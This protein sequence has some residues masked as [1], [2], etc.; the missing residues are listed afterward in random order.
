MLMLDKRLAPVREKDAVIPTYSADTL[1][2]S[3]AIVETVYSTHASTHMSMGDT[4]T[5]VEKL[6]HWTRHNKGCVIGAIV[7]RYGYGK[8]STAVHLWYECEKNNVI[9]V[10]PFAWFGL[11]DIIGATYTWVNYR[12]EQLAPDYCQSLRFIYDRYCAQSLETIAEEEGTTIEVLKGLL[13]KGK[14][15]LETRPPDVVKFLAEVNELVTTVGREGPVVFT[16]ELQVTLSEYPTRDQFMEDLFGVLNELHHHQG[17]YGIVISMPTATETLIADVRRDI[18]D[19]MQGFNFYIRPE[20]MYGRS[21]ASDLWRKYAQVFG[22][23]DTM[24]NILPP[25]TLKSIGQ[26]ASRQD[27]G[28]GPRTVVDAFRRAIAYY[29]ESNTTYQPTDLIDD[30]LHGEVAFDQNGKL[31]QVVREALGVAPVTGNTDNE[32]AIKLL[33]AFPEGCSEEIQHYYDVADIISVLPPAYRREYLY[34]FAEGPSLR[35][36]AATEV[37]PD[38]VFLRLAKEFIGRYKEDTYHGQLALTAFQELIL[39]GQIFTERRGTSLTGWKWEGQH[40]LSGTF[41]ESYPDRQLYL[42]AALTQEE[43]DTDQNVAEF[44]IWIQL[45]L[46]SGNQDPG[47][48]RKL[49]GSKKAFLRLNAMRRPSVVLNIAYLSDLGL[50]LTRLTPLFMLALLQFLSNNRNAIPNEEQA[51][52]MKTFT[53]QLLGNVVKLLFHNE[54][55]EQSEWALTLIGTDMV[56]DIFNQMCEA[57]YPAYVTFITMRGWENHLNLYINALSN[58]RVTVAMAHGRQ[59]LTGSKDEIVRL[60]GQGSSQAFQNFQRSIPHLLELTNWA[61][62]EQGQIKFKLHPLEQAILDALDASTAKTKVNG[63]LAGELGYDELNDLFRRQGYLATELQQ[64]LRLLKARR[65]LKLDERKRKFARLIESP[66][67]LQHVINEKLEAIRN[68]LKLLDESVGD[69][70]IT[71]F[72]SQVAMLARRAERATGVSE[73]EE[74][75]LAVNRLRNEIDH[76]VETHNQIYKDQIQKILDDAQRNANSRLSVPE[77]TH[78]SLWLPRS[79]ALQ[80]IVEVSVFTVSEVATE[81]LESSKNLLD[82]ARNAET[83]SSRLVILYRGQLTIHATFKRLKELL[84]KAYY[85]TEQ[86]KVWNILLEMVIR[87]KREVDNCADTY[88]LPEFRDQFEALNQRVGHEIAAGRGFE[89][90]PVLRR[91]L[92]KLERATQERI[93]GQRDRFMALKMQRETLLNHLSSHRIGLHASFDHYRP[94]ESQ[95]N[96]EIEVGEQLERFMDELSSKLSRVKSDL[97][98]LSLIAKNPILPD[99]ERVE[100]VEHEL[101]ES[102][103]GG[104]TQMLELWAERFLYAQMQIEQLQDQISSLFIKQAPNAAEGQLLTILSDGRPMELGEVVRHLAEKQGAQGFSLDQ[105]VTDVQSLFQKNQ[106][107]IKLECRR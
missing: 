15:K 31:G 49:G 66:E 75:H 70:D 77:I 97:S 55:R 4:S 88:S 2:T 3:P 53:D 61:G 1:I 99:T 41:Q 92:E 59:A 37:R 68:D 16:D 65:Y 69:F 44:G 106:I 36:L 6:I 38:P 7:G 32:F 105:L 40:E 94:I 48:I 95:Q 80:S 19:R 98:Y 90:M 84:Q 11:T 78:Q 101:Q 62:R 28:A 47:Q 30:Y 24:S 50:P 57:S 89:Y 10:P 52:N 56:K 20:T 58:P 67:E 22:F 91:E 63:V 18:I 33:G 51:R 102:L 42:Q 12:L 39:R 100:Q 43:L 34:D 46:E 60:F 79:Q 17:S 5:F 27:L 14:L 83:S 45:S 85:N 64:A 103:K 13:D 72:S 86:F 25:Y 71:R 26:I 82:E 23:V 104:D 29:D 76:Q 73:L 8:T 54:L 9:A 21:F 74:V 87:V 107:I 35:K 81:L 96:L 93:S